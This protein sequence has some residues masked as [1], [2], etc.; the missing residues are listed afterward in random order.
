MVWEG[1]VVPLTLPLRRAVL[2]ILKVTSRHVTRSAEVV[3]GHS[4]G[5]GHCP[6]LVP[7]TRVQAATRREGEKGGGKGDNVGGEIRKAAAGGEGID[8]GDIC[9][10]S[11]V[12]YPLK[13]EKE[14]L[15]LVLRFGKVQYCRRKGVRKAGRQTDRQGGRDEGAEDE[16]MWACQELGLAGLG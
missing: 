12:R 15:L 1:G 11:F 10:L 16:V 7:I 4:S 8:R 14:G 3:G 6:A 5:R 13:A 2:V 9:F